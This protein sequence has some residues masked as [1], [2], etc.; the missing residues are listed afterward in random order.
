MTNSSFHARPLAPVVAITVAFLL[1]GCSSGSTKE[2]APIKEPIPLAEINQ[3]DLASALQ[4]IVPASTP[5][6]SKLYDVTVEMCNDDLDAMKALFASA[7][8]SGNTTTPDIMRVMMQAVCPSKSHM[9][10]DAIG[11]IHDS[12]SAVEQA[13]RTPKDQRT[14]RQTLLAEAIGCD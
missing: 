13:C 2:P 4:I 12:A 6:V 3:A 14:D 5:D 7:I 11:Q 10:D 8:D 9:A 1:G